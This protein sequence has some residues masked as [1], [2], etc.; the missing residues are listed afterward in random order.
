[1]ERVS[2][3][4]ATEFELLTGVGAMISESDDD[5][6]DDGDDDDDDDDGDDGDDRKEG[7]YDCHTHQDQGSDCWLMW[8]FDMINLT[9][10]C[11]SWFFLA[12]K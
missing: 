2:R 8:N 6:D 7:G 11:P 9:K 10:T 4:T 12:E 3:N 5:D 1:V